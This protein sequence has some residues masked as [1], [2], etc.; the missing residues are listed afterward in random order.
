MNTILDVL[1]GENEAKI[2]AVFLF[3][4]D[5][6]IDLV[7]KK[8]LY[9]TRYFFLQFFEN[10]DA[11]FHKEIDK[12]NIGVYLNGGSFLNIGFRNSAKTTRTKLFTAFAIANDESKH[13]KYIKVLSKDL[14]NAKQIT[15]DVYNLLISKRVKAL[16]PEIFEKTETKREETMASLQP[17]LG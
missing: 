14:K 2:K 17:L 9:W 12:K 6:D 8:F 15:T 16:Y 11:P 1:N 4:K 5:D 13:R 10:P 3:N 7:R